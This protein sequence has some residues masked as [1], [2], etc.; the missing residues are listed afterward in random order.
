MLCVVDGPALNRSG[1]GKKASSGENEQNQTV[2]ANVKVGEIRRE[3]G[4]VSRAPSSE[5]A[6]GFKAQFQAGGDT[7]LATTAVQV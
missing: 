3:R 1:P 7:P 5:E 2:G 4:Q 6:K